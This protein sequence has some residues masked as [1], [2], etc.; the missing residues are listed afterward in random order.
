MYYRHTP[1][2]IIIEHYHAKL[3]VSTIE[4]QVSWDNTN[5]EDGG[6]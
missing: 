1:H 4:R 2:N 6:H 3:I 5:G